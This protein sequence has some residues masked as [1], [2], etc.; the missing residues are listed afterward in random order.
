MPQTRA[1]LKTYFV[2]NAIP[3][4][5]NF[6]ELIEA[7]LN[8]ADDGIFKTG[9]D[10]LS[11]VAAPEGQRR[12]LRLY[13]SYPADNADWLLSLNPSD[14]ADSTKSKAGLGF[15][16]GTGRTRL[17]IDPTSGSLGLGTVRP[18]DL[19]SLNNGDLRVSGGENRQ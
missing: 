15:A 14:P 18:D 5:G 9:G 16:D 12:V 7:P 6:A 10:P 13:S 17:Y 1:K 3:T 2:A 8:Q 11:V 4:A 19:L